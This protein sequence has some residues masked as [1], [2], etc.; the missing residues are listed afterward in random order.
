MLRDGTVRGTRWSSHQAFVIAAIGAT[1]GLGN[2]WRFP[3]LVAEH[4]GLAF[5]AVYLVVLGL[6]GLPLLLAEL[7]LARRVTG[8]LPV[9]FPAE[10]R[11]S[12]AAPAWRAWPWLVMV[13]AWMVL[14]C[15][16]VT[17]SWLLG[18]L[19]AAFQGGFAN[20]TPRAVA[21]RFDALAS[22]P[23]VAIGWLTLFLGSAV[24]VSAAGVRRSVEHAAWGGLVLAGFAWGTALIGVLVD[25]EAGAGFARLYTFDPS[26][27]GG[28]GLVAALT[29]AFY[30]LTLGVG[31]MHAYATHLPP[32]G[33]LPMLAWRI[34]LADTLFALLAT[35]VVLGLLA[36]A[37]LEPATGPRLLFERLP[38]AFARVAGGGWLAVALYSGLVVLAWLTT[39]ALLEPLVLALSSWR[40]LGRAR[41]ALLVGVSLWLAT[42]LLLVAFA[43]T[44]GGRWAGQGP[45]GWLEF[46]GG[47]LLT[48]LAALLAALFVGWQLEER[49]CRLVLALVPEPLYRAWRVLLRYL[50]PPLL[51]LLLL[52]VTGILPGR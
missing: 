16:L 11:L 21:L 30:T 24:A 50:A 32:G 6:L 7:V 12:Q 40:R 27:L 35:L 26:A 46:L 42:T 9:H 28:V 1:L 52:V 33:A 39:L 29:Q 13:A 38:L 34:V 23:T 4:G 8:A 18:Y 3:G 44:P 31:V 20:P 36:A 43:G 45:Y 15:L 22:A 17:G 48:P 41:A 2:A 51:V 5:V 47:R 37:G 19:A 14:A 49:S 25:G 10:V